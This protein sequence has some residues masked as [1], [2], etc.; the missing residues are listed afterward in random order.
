M[1]TPWTWKNTT[2]SCQPL[3]KQ[4]ACAAFAIEVDGQEQL[5]VV[6]EVNRPRKL[7]LDAVAESIRQ[8]VQMEHRVPLYALVFIKAGTLPK[9]SSGKVQRQ[10]T[11]ELFSR[12]QLD[13][14]RQWRFASTLGTLSA[15]TAVDRPLPSKDEIRGWLVARI[16]RHCRVP[17]NQINP[18]EAIAHYVLDSVSAVTIAMEIQQ[19]LGRAVP[20]T[21]LYDSPSLLLLAERLAD[22]QSYTREGEQAQIDVDRLTSDELDRALAQMLDGATTPGDLPGKTAE[23]DLN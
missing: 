8:A 21:V 6:Q 17:E 14:I 15:P 16:A 1:F 5:V 18:R 9:T 13:V 7:D 4:N 19:W 11:R 3:L 12:D 22:P 10:A 2:F 20:Q 23:K